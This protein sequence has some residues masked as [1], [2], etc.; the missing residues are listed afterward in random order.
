MPPRSGPRVSGGRRLTTKLS[1]PWRRI[2][3]KFWWCSDV[4]S[5]TKR[6]EGWFVSKSGYQEV[7]LEPNLGPFK[8]AREA[9]LAWEEQRYRRIR[10]V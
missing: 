5:A 3:R 1:L 4:G 7:L 9:M 2:N 10:D 8:T 6:S